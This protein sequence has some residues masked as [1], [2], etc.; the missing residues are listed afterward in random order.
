M[1]KEVIQLRSHS[2]DKNKLVRVSENP[3]EYKLVIHENNGDSVSVHEDKKLIVA[4]DP[5]GGPMIWINDVFD[6]GG[7]CNYRVAGFFWRPGGWIITFKESAL[8]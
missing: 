5:S 8:G 2:W 6:L 7:T 4:I 3:I 1:L